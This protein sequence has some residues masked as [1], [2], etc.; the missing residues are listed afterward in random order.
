LRPVGEAE[1]EI[2]KL[3][4]AHAGLLEQLKKLERKKKKIQKAESTMAQKVKK[5]LAEME[6]VDSLFGPEP[7]WENLPEEETMEA[8]ERSVVPERLSPEESPVSVRDAPPPCEVGKVDLPPAA[9]QTKSVG[10]SEHQSL[11]KKLCGLFDS[12]FS[13]YADHG[14]SDGSNGIVID[15]ATGYSGH[16][17]LHRSQAP[18]SPTRPERFIRMMGEHRGVST[19]GL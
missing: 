17:G 8:S 12:F 10:L 7:T 11:E 19:V 2:C 5:A 13:G 14:V 3:E 15:F 1:E 9:E 18:K 6:S 4:S 16:R